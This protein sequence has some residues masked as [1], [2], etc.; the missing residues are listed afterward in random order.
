MDK[1]EFNFLKFSQIVCTITFAL[2][3]KKFGEARY[4]VSYLSKVI[5]TLEQEHAST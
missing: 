2:R 1:I 5:D 3:N 4:L